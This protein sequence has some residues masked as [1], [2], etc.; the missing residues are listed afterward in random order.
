[1]KNLSWFNFRLLLICMG[2]SIV[3]ETPMIYPRE[4]SKFHVS[5]FELESG[6]KVYLKKDDSSSLVALALTVGVGS[7]TEGRWSGS[8]ISHLLE[9]L[10]FKGAHQGGTSEIGEKIEKF[11]GDINAFTTPDFTLYYISIPKQHLDVAIEVLYE[12]VRELSFDDSS[13]EKE[14]QVILHEIQM[15]MDDPDRILQKFFWKTAYRVHPY[16]IKTIGYEDLLLKLTPKDVRDYFQEMYAPE[17][18]SLTVV[19]DID[20]KDV[21][22]AVRDKFGKIQRRSFS[23][24]NIPS[25]PSVLRPRKE[26]TFENIKLSRLA[27]GFLVP[28]F[29][30]PDMVA[31]DMLASV[32]GDGTQS[33]LYQRLQEES[34]LTRSVYASSPSLIDQGLFSIYAVYPDENQEKVEEGIQQVIEKI[35]KDRISEDELKRVKNQ[36]LSDFYRQLDSTDRQAF[37]IGMISF[38][39]G[40]ANYILSYLN[41]VE[42]V[43]AEDVQNTARKYLNPNQS[44]TCLMRPKSME[45]KV[46]L[47]KTS[48]SNVK[49]FKETFKNGASLIIEEDHSIPLVSLQA[50]FKGGVIE[51]N[52]KNNGL[53]SLMTSTAIR[54]TRKKSANQIFQIIESAGGSLSSFSD[55]NTFGFSLSIPSSSLKQAADILFE[56][57]QEANFPEDQILKQREQSYAKIQEVE[58]ST[59]AWGM[60]QFKKSMFSH[61]PYRLLSYGSADSIKNITRKDLESAFEK[62]CRPDNM[63][64]AVL[65]DISSADGDII[66]K[67]IEHMAKPRQP[68]VFE[69]H[70]QEFKKLSPVHQFKEQNQSLV[71]IGFPGVRIQDEDRYALEILAGTL[72][73]FGSPLFKTIRNEMGAAYY[74][75]AM[76]LFGLDPG[77]FIIYAGTDPD[78]EK[79]VAEVIGKSIED[80][81]AK[82]VSEED[83]FRAKNQLIADHARELQI[84]SSKA[85]EMARMEIYGLG[86]ES[87][88]QYESRIQA[89]QSGDLLRIAKKYF[90]V[91]KRLNFTISPAASQK[92]DEEKK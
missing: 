11:G 71:M 51:E 92:P 83:I 58:E 1:M 18:T 62:Y 82:E 60:F 5:S 78:H 89:V 32:L 70:E 4:I 48:A 20:E 31:I 77:A 26:E 28:G 9:H 87:L 42:S 53:F 52:D 63:V 13:L 36:I 45:K 3:I 90:D 65:G 86:A 64:L 37:W 46:S 66:R 88:E 72:S 41:Q 55:Q 69:K 47:E 40:D 14:K 85:R 91:S 67:N 79:E 6:M 8:G 2:I 22:E 35:K 12:S 17:N 23:L 10:V 57:L 19:G 30:H 7:R 84:L 80:L 34:H 24:P 15:G 56:I 29:G 21:L 33:R 74:V 39:A 75:G 81:K 54:G 44:V 16:R 49:A 68:L 73:G 59:M 25:E 43:T 76:N 50:V 61:H 38:L 27:L